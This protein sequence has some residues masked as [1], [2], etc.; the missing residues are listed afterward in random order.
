MGMHG[1]SQGQALAAAMTADV[2]RTLKPG[3]LFMLISHNG[4]RQQ[5]VLDS[6]V[7]AKHGPS[8]QWNLLELRKAA[9]SPKAMLINVMRSKLNGKPLMEGFR[10]PAMLKEAAEET[11]FA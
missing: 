11:R 8:A 5:Q 2:W 4:Q 1:G 7:E 10:D 9:L 3:G 6:A